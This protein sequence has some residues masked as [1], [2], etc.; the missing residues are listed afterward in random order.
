MMRAWLIEGGLPEL[1]AVALAHFVARARE[2]FAGAPEL[3]GGLD[4]D[5][6]A[7][8]WHGATFHVVEAVMAG[9]LPN[10]PEQL[11]R[12]VARWNLQALGLKPRTVERALAA[13]PGARD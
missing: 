5:L 3:L 9:A 7:Q 2:F 12:F 1:R 11:G 6:V 4:V 8:A 13:L 10:E